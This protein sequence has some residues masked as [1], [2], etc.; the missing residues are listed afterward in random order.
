MKAHLR[1]AAREY[2][3][4]LDRP[5]SLASELSFSAEDPRYFGAPAASSQPLAIAGFSGSVA[6]GAS[7]NCSTVSLTPHCNG[8]H[9][10]CVGHL[11]TQPLDAFRVVPPGLLP[12]VLVSVAP[13]N[14]ACAGETSLPQPRAQDALI[15]QRLLARA[16]SAAQ[17]RAAAPVC[18]LVIRTLPDRDARRDAV[19]PYL[20]KEAVLWIVECGIEHLVVELPSVDRLEDD[21]LLTA[22]RVFF[23]LPAGA[24]DLGEA[25]RPGCTI[26]ELACVPGTLHDGEYLL[27]LQVPA[28]AGD[29]VPSRPLL[30]ALAET[31]S[32]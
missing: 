5:V 15:T 20:S 10:E 24:R 7:C 3:V 32:S 2:L 9:T 19:P 29:A 28:I 14:A 18:A 30:Y 6:A 25:R 26:T 31:G 4:D 17:P 21:G 8:T 23:G 16:W 1:A 22:H 11:T 12:A 27:E 13:E